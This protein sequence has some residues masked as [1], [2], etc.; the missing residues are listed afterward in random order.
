MPAGGSTDGTR[1]DNVSYTRTAT[2]R[3]A[4]DRR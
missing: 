2:A 4:S 3:A 1:A